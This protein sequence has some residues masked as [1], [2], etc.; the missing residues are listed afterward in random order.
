M[1]STRRLNDMDPLHL[2]GYAPGADATG[3]PRPGDPP[4]SRPSPGA[5]PERRPAGGTCVDL[6]L[7]KFS[8]M[9]GD[10]R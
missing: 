1:W 8:T 4:L 10:A 3:Y 7:G 2:V 6:E 5:I 9:P